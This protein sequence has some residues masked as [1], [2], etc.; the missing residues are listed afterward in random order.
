MFFLSSFRKI[1]RETRLK[2]NG[3]TYLQTCQC[4]TDADDIAVMARTKMKSLEEKGNERNKN[5]CAKNKIHGN[6]SEQR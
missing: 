2:T 5:K 4:L 3:T 1:T 6:Y